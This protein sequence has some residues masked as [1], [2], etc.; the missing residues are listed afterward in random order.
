MSVLTYIENT[1]SK[2]ILSDIEK[3]S[4]D[5]SI[6]SLRKRLSDFFG[7]EIQEHLRF[8]SS[9]RGTILPRKADKN[10]DIDYMIIFSN[11]NGY[12]PNAFLDRLRKFA[13]AKYPTSEIYR[14]HPTVVLD[15]NHI[16]FELVPA[17]KSWWNINIPAPN[18]SFTSWTSTDPNGFNRELTTKNSLHHQQIKP[19]IRLVK[20]WNASN[21]YIYDSFSLERSLLSNGYYFCRN[22]KEYFF[23]AMEHLSVYNLPQYKVNKVF[24]A[25]RRVSNITRY[26]NAGYKHLAEDEVKKLLAEH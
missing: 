8:G 20:Y 14:S 18:T 15:L 12:K 22:L 16:K 19:M 3:T 17:Y 9:T 10:S 11:V 24:L 7:S 2:L 13:E 1:A 4:I 23:Y 26:E 21:D 25:K 6:D 5:V